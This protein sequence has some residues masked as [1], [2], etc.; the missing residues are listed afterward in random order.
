[1]LNL[2]FFFVGAYGE[3]RKA[4]HKK[5]NQERAVKIINKSSTTKEDQEKLIN[6]VNILRE[7]VIIFFYFNRFNYIFFTFSDKLPTHSFSF[8]FQFFRTIRISSK[9]LSFI[10]MM[11]FSI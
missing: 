11:A 10:K 3:V 1:M 8:S 4:I 7:L 2:F 9:F 6:E 5:T